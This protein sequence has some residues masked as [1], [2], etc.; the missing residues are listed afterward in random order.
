[1][2]KFPPKY[3][4]P[5]Y[6]K[7]DRDCYKLVV[8]LAH[9]KQI[10]KILGTKDKMNE[11]LRLLV[12]SQKMDN[13]RNFLRIILKSLSSKQIDIPKILKQKF[14]IPK[15]YE[16][17]VVRREHR[18]LSNFLD[19]FGKEQLQFIGSD[20]ETVEFILRFTLAQQLLDWKGSL[21]AIKEVIDGKSQVTLKSLNKVLSEFD[22]TNVFE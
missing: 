10:P 4:Y 6:D 18:E 2:T 9:Q 20:K 15:G 16:N 5:L 17:W 21:L 3:R 12:Q 14:R 1:M 19:R 22:Y 7:W 11:F 8:K 13:W